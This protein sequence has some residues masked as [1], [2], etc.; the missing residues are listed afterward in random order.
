V[1]ADAA[2]QLQ[3]GF[4]IIVRDGACRIHVVSVAITVVV[5]AIVTD[6]LRAGIDVRVTVVAIVTAFADIFFEADLAV[7]VTVAIAIAISEPDAT[8][9]VLAVILR[10]VVTVVT[11]HRYTCYAPLFIRLVI[12]WIAALD[13]IAAVS[14]IAF[15]VNRAVLAQVGELVAVVFRAGQAVIAVELADARRSA[16]RIRVRFAYPPI[17]HLDTIAEDP[18]GAFDVFTTEPVL[19]THECVTGT[20]SVGV[21]IG[22]DI[23]VTVTIAAVRVIAGLDGYQ[24]DQQ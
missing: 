15:V 11:D 1:H 13:S 5:L 24:H 19:G 7:P 17:T 3:G 8:I 16:V 14:V 12:T 18:V 10:A 21:G 6:F 4:T 20:I 2:P 22:V 23:G 9:V